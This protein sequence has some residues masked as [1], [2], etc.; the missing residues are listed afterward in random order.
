MLIPRL[1]AKQTVRPGWNK[2]GR[3]E[4]N[5]MT[6]NEKQPHRSD[7]WCAYSWNG[8]DGPYSWSSWIS[9]WNLAGLCNNCSLTLHCPHYTTLLQLSPDWVL[10]VVHMEEKRRE[11]SG[12]SKQSRCSDRSGHIPRQKG[13]IL[14]HSIKDEQ[15]IEL[16]RFNLMDKEIQT[17][18][19]FVEF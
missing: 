11:Q 1:E 10:W 9:S 3:R 17:T 18:N 5:N 4:V 2:H 15:K 12:E 14:C 8:F 19:S 7:F 6:W 13:T 16:P